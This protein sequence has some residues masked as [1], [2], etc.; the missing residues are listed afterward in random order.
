MQPSLVKCK[1]S[2]F[3]PQHFSPTM[4]D[5]IKIIGAVKPLHY[6]GKTTLINEWPSLLYSIR[7]HLQQS[8]FET[9]DSREELMLFSFN[10]PHSAITAIF[11]TIALLKKEFPATAADG[12][13]PFHFIL[14][15]PQPGEVNSPIQNPDTNVWK[16][17]K[18]ESIY[19]S[20]PLKLNWESLMAQKKLPPFTIQNE[21][22][23]IFEVKFSADFNPAQETKLL[24][25]RSMGTKGKL[26]TCFYCGLRTHKPQYCPSK[27]L[28]MDDEGIAWVGYLPFEQINMIYKNL[29]QNQEPLIAMF[30]AGLKPGQSR[31]T[32]KLLIYLSFMEICRAYQIRFLINM[33]F[34]PFNSWDSVFNSETLSFD[35]NSLKLGFDCLRVQQYAQAEKLFLEESQ[36]NSPKKFYAKIGLAFIAL[37]R[38]RIGDMRT[39]LE[40][41]SDMAIQDKERIY[42]ALL[43]SRLYELGGDDFKSRDALKNVS[44]L[45]RDCVEVNYRRMQVEAKETFNEYAFQHLRSML[46]DDRKV[47]MAAFFDPAFLLIE[48]KL[49]SILSTRFNNILKH[50]QA[51]LAQARHEMED[52]ALWFDEEDPQMHANVKTI[53]N[54]TKRFERKS[55]FDMIDVNTKSA[56]LVSAGRKLRESKLN[57][58]FEKANDTM[59]RWHGYNG[60]WKNYEYQKFFNQFIDNLFPLRKKIESSISL[61]KKNRGDTYRHSS[62]ELEEVLRSMDGLELIYTRMNNFAQVCRGGKIFAKKLLLCE[63]AVGIGLGA[64]IA[65]AALGA[66]PENLAN[67][68]IQIASDPW[69]QKK[70]FMFFSLIIAPVLAFSW[71]MVTLNE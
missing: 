22:E 24:S 11:S 5:D 56:A 9:E 31:K 64:V 70:T 54:L 71:T 42:I 65:A 66:L 61:A 34:S 26:N 19:I 39:Q 16:I 40:S 44:S 20:R 14:H 18:T 27:Y 21:G 36:Q 49:E 57:G 28:S 69:K 59:N 3:S 7:T 63:V 38:D 30:T 2:G 15:L 41:A 1:E 43:L 46:A 52:L 58:L 8:G 55:Y 51:N 13:V 12:G 48:N 23:G 4:T 53:E 45:K 6:L 10:H 62:Q 29:F 35:N 68:L 60:Y 50:A 47:F 33:S 37:E 67:S 32:P 17:L 25:F